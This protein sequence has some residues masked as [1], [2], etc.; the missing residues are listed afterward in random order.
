[1]EKVDQAY[2]DELLMSTSEPSSKDG[3]KELKDEKSETE[4]SYDAIKEMSKLMGRGNRDLDMNVIMMFLKFLL[5]MWGDQ[6][7]NRSV[8][9]KM[10]TRGKMTLATFTQTQVYLKP[11]LQKLKNRSLPEDISDSLTEIVRHLLNR[12]YIMVI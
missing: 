12:N 2:L 11:L 10:G 3:K 5:K 4:L 6:L 8:T 7:N 1:M 9:E